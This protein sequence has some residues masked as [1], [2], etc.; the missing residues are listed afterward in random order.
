[1]T[2]VAEGNVTITATYVAPTETPSGAPIK[3]AG[4][5][6][7]AEIEL[8]VTPAAQPGEGQVLT[9]DGHTVTLVG[10]HYTD[11][12]NY[13]LYITSEE[14]MVGLG[15]SFWHINGNETSDL[16]TNIEISEDGHTIICSTQS[17]S[18]PQLY[19]P[20]YVLMPGEVNFGNVVIEWIEVGSTVGVTTVKADT[21]KGFNV[22]T[23]DGRVLQHGGET[24]IDL[25]AGLYIING[26]KVIV[27]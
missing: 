24:L 12:D 2:A 19:T 18:E 23:I 8:T 1:M 4:E 15:G 3:A 11:T 27:K 22:Y 20:L 17:T 9:A 25:P 5:P 13:E 14:Q 10:R 7:T 16:R 6:I 21:N 26:K